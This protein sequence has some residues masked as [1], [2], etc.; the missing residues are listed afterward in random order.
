[1]LPAKE[2]R[3]PSDLHFYI[4]FVTLMLMMGYKDDFIH[5]VEGAI[6]T[7]TNI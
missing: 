7:V 5:G 6:K 1:M 3:V 2:T 4:F